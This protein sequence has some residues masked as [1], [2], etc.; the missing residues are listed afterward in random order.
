MCGLLVMP[1]VLRGS[2]I[3]KKYIHSLGMISGS[4]KSW[5]TLCHGSQGLT[6]GSQHGSQHGTVRLR[7]RFCSNQGEPDVGQPIQGYELHR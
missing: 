1:P 4:V 7:P 5:V 3:G 2:K 6:R